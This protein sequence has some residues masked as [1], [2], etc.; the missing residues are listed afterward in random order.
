MT[1]T[2]QIAALR[3][4]GAFYDDADTSSSTSDFDGPPEP[5]IAQR[6]LDTIADQ[7]CSRYQRWL[8]GE[9]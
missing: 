7:E 5:C 9:L 6:D 8:E 4:L 2:A 1:T 3:S